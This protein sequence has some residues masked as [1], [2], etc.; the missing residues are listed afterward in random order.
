MRAGNKLST[1]L[2]SSIPLVI[3]FA[4]LFVLARALDRKLVE[5][6][7]DFDTPA[8]LQNRK[9]RRAASHNRN[10]VETEPYY[11]KFNHNNLK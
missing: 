5:E 1:H 6:N 4:T 9:S 3:G 2:T 7:N 10:P 8:D 11:Q